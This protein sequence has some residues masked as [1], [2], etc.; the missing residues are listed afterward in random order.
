V[1]VDP[2]ALAALVDRDALMQCVL[3]YARGLDR[4]D[5]DLVISAFHPD[6]VFDNGDFR[7][8]REGFADWLWGQQE[9]RETVQHFITNPTFELD[10][11]EAHGETYFLAAIRST[12]QEGATLMGGRY[13]DRFERRDGRWAIAARVLVREWHLSLATEQLE[14]VLAYG[15]RLARRDGGDV[16]YARPLAPPA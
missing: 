10:G 11:D 2:A 7:G 15:R 5:L 6:A 4:L 13:L 8:T 12:G 14:S 9:G 16:S 3:A 1:G